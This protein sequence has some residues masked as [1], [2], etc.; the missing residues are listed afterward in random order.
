VI[1]DHGIQQTQTCQ[2]ILT[3]F[4]TTLPGV[5]PLPIKI[6]AVNVGTVYIAM[7]PTP[8]N[9]YQP[10]ALIDSKFKVVSRSAQ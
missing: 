8:A 5:S 1:A 7:S 9:H 2:K 10:Y 6:Y 3:V 4:Y